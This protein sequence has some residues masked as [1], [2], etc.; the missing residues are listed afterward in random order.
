M[1]SELPHFLFTIILVATQSK[2]IHSAFDHKL[3]MCLL[4][5]AVTTGYAV[6][7]LISQLQ[8]VCLIWLN[9]P[10]QEVHL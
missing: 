6:S 7:L 10:G 1:K 2:Y 8:T 5:G 9:A 3:N 4:I